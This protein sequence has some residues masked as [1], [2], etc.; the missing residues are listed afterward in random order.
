M[1]IF[2]K[3]FLLTYCTLL[4]NDS[5]LA[6]DPGHLG[7]STAAADILGGTYEFL[8]ETDFITTELLKCIHD[9]AHK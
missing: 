8:A 1:K 6:Q 2:E 7:G 4:T 9:L 5:K 3:R